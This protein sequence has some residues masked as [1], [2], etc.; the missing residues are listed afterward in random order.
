MFEIVVKIDDYVLEIEKTSLVLKLTTCVFLNQT[1]QVAVFILTQ[2]NKKVAVFSSLLVV[3]VV[4]VALICDVN[5]KEC[6]YG[7]KNV[8]PHDDKYVDFGGKCVHKY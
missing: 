6:S 2:K 7:E 5:I 8:C 1:Q 4:S 3:V